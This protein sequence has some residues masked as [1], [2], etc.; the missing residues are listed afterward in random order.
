ML[1]ESLEELLAPLASPRYVI[2]R[3]VVH[4]PL[5]RRAAIAQATMRLLRLPVSGAVAYHAV[6]AYLAANRARVHALVAAWR[7]H[8]GP[9]TALYAGSPEGGAVLDLHRGADPFGVTSQIRMLWRGLLAW[10]DILRNRRPSCWRSRR[11]GPI[12]E[13]STNPAAGRSSWT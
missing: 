10:P 11:S 7:A 4:Q 6:P 13:Q 12:L 8:V 1:A 9:T 5:T 3:R 2:G